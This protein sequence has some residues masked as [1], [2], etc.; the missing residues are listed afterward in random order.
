MT[1]PKIR[2]TVY[3]HKVIDVV[4]FYTNDHAEWDVEELLDT[5]YFKIIDSMDTGQGR[6]RIKVDRPLS[7]KDT[8]H[9]IGVL[10]KNIKKKDESRR[11]WNRLTLEGERA[12]Y[13]RLKKK[14]EGAVDS[15]TA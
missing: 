12:E 5:L 13:E 14:F 9:R 7:D 1:A 10:A 11:R 15:S 8:E 3:S 4:E 2:T 6:I